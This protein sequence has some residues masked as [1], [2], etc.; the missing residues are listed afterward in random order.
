MNEDQTPH[1]LAAEL[2]RR[3]DM[4]V[5]AG[6]RQRKAELAALAQTAPELARRLAALLDAHECGL[7]G[8]DQLGDTMRASLGLFDIDDLLG[9]ELGGWTLTGLLGRGGMGIVFA[10]ER[11]HENVRQ[12]AAVKL[13]SIPLFDSQASE[14]FRREALVLAR[15][16]HPDICRLRDFGR[17]PEGWPYLVLDRID[18]VPLHLYAESHSLNERLGLVARVAD[19]VAAAHRQLVVHLDI[20]PENVLVTAAGDPVLLDFG[21]ARVLGEED[22]HSATATVT[23]WMTPDYAAPERLRGEP[24]GVSADLYS[25]GA[26]LYRILTGARPFE[27]AGLSLTDALAKIEKGIEPPSRRTATLPRDLDAVL[28]KAMHPDPARRYASATEFSEDLRAVVA[29]RPVRARPDNL[30]YRLRTALRRHPVALPA[31]GVALAAIALMAG[32]LAWQ[33]GDL[34]EQRDRAGREAA[35]ASAANELLLDAIQAADPAGATAEDLRVTTLVDQWARQLD[36]ETSRPADVRAAAFAALGQ[37]R[38][39]LGQFD[40]ALHMFEQAQA[41]YAVSAATQVGESERLVPALGRA[42]VLHRLDRLDDAMAAIDQIQ[43]QVPETEHWRLRMTRGTIL[44]AQSHY[45]E[46]E[47]EVLAALD[48]APEEAVRSRVVMMSNMGGIASFRGRPRDAFPWYER[49]LEAAAAHPEVREE[50]ASVLLNYANDLSL[51]GEYAAA[52]E[53]MQEAL[54]IRLAL[55][56]EAHYRSVETLGAQA[57][58]FSDMGDYERALET[59]ERAL[60][61][62]ERLTG[63]DSVRAGSLWTQVGSAHGQQRGFDQA[64][65]AHRRA[66]D[67]FLAHLPEDHVQVGMARNNLATALVADRRFVEAIPEYEK[68]WAIYA[69]TAAGEPSVY[70]AII[71]ANLG[72]AH[73]QLGNQPEGI[74]WARRAMTHAEATLPETHPARL[75]MLNVLAENLHATGKLGEAQT[76]ASV[77]EQAYA[78]SETPVSPKSLHANWRLLAL[79]AEA[80]GDVAAAAHWREKMEALDAET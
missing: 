65:A 37:V 62:E 59:A 43:A 24:S 38:E 68:V 46:A 23:R 69:A 6:T 77:V 73:V 9:R 17:S 2:E 27:L 49:A 28:R 5:N 26:L 31:G 18:G 11:E 70:L 29:R 22:E 61:L 34:R 4:L 72:F 64:A 20:K 14:R 3:F 15:L 1:D 57:G 52:A 44:I 67:A 25:L 60:A 21:I 47:P 45:D 42:R 71:A 50:R 12:R 53:R 10:A 75:H 40:Q 16:D 36:T 56:G 55:Y 63:G 76:A 30:G 78:V 80:R 74:D 58:V 54:D 41:L 7:D 32:I 19:A 39:S 79:I 13:L 48:G 8:I 35:R 33:A 51:L 66:L